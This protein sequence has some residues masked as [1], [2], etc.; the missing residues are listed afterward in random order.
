MK[1]G[2]SKFIV[3]LCFVVIIAF[4]SVVL[5]MYWNGHPVPDSLIYCIFLCFGIEFASLAAVKSAKVKTLGTRVEM[6][7][8]DPSDFTNGKHAG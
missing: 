1:S 2:F 3:V 4:S 8:V 7:T 5:F 6:P